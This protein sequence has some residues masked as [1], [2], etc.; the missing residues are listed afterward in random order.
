M[1]EETSNAMN[2]DLNLGPSPSPDLG[3]GSMPGEDLSLDEC[4]DE[5]IHRLRD[6][7]R[8]RVPQRWRRQ[9]VLIPPGV[10]SIPVDLNE[11]MVNFANGTTLH[12]GEGSAAAGQSTN[13]VPKSCENNTGFAEDGET[14]KDNVVKGGGKNGSFF[15]C[16]ICLDLTRDPVVTS[17]GHLFCWPCLYQW[18]HAREDVKECPVC[19]EQVT[20][21]N[22]TPIYGRGNYGLRP[23]D[24]PGMKIPPRPHAHRVESLRQTIQRT[25]L[26]FPIEEMIRRLGSRFG[27]TRDLIP[28][29][30]TD[31][32]LETV[33]R[34]SSLI[35]RFLLARGMRNREQ[36]PILP[37]G[38]GVDLA[39]AAA[40]NLEGSEIR[41]LHSILLRRSQSHRNALSLSSTLT[42]DRLVEAYYRN[43]NLGRNQDQPP[44]VDDRDSFSSIAAVINSESQVDTAIEIDSL[45]SHSSSTS[46]RRSDI[47]RA[48]DLDNGHSRASRRRRLN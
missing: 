48:P 31:S 24:D 5:P 18:L 21:K 27:L 14:D 40:T 38:D 15:D 2:L 28:P 13:V 35:D 6:A 45:V 42:A 33:S 22:V 11:L 37:S 30:E 44:P 47:S 7:A 12:A 34:T 17:C 10:H 25:S 3:S 32:T 26:N 46:R 1:A 43:H 39:Q 16:N 20:D 8:H 4:I 36:N 29:L 9:Q 19:K 23:A 41:R